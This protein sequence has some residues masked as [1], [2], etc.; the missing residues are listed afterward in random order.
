MKQGL[1]DTLRFLSEDVQSESCHHQSKIMMCQTLLR[2]AE[3]EKM[4]FQIYVGFFSPNSLSTK[5]L[6]NFL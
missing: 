3:Y 6:A 4:R 5:D 2:G 1:S